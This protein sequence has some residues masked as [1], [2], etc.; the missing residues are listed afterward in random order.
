M[1]NVIIV[2]YSEIHLKGKN[3]GFFENLLKQNIREKLRGMD[4]TEEFV[5]GRYVVS[6][7]APKDENRIINALC[8]VFGIFSLSRAVRTTAD[9]A[10][11]IKAAEKICPTEGTFRVTVNRADKRLPY[12]SVSLAAEVGGALLE[13]RGGKLEVDLH[14]PEHTVYVDVR[15][16]NVAYVYSA[17]I[18]G[19][20]GM[21]VGSAGRGL[22]LLSGGIDSPVSSYMMAKRGLKL[23]ALH[24]WSYP[25]TSLEARDKVIELAR[26]LSDYTG[27][28]EVLVVPFTKVQESIH[29]YAESNYMI[30]LVRR[31][32][33]RIAERVAEARGLQCIING[34]DLGQVAS[35]TMES[36]TVTN[37]VIK[38]L[39]VFRPL[40]GFDKIDIIEMSKKIGTYDVSIRPFEDCCTVFLPDSPVTKPTIRRA[41]D[42]ERKIGNYDELI[43]EAVHD[44][45]VF[46]VPER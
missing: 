42:N 41:E 24:F 30:T 19:A 15:E 8:K 3:R 37:S 38:H 28:M 14:D 22:T 29:K 46:V 35:Q 40:I 36:L 45:E 2:R 16:Q 5:Y 31:A 1:D 39:P 32:M 23:T 6:G 18:P 10:D 34:E 20:G 4:C 7:Y 11:I 21:P 26:L 33:M 44:L 12:T 27:R 25:Y 9:M 17:N 13:F 43:D